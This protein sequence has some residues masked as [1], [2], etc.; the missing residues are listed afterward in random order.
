SKNVW[1]RGVLPTSSRSLC[2]PPARTH[3]CEVVARLYGRLSTPVNTSL[4]WTMPAFVNSSVGS[5]AGTS[6][7]DATI[8]W[9][10]LRKNSRNA[11]R[12]SAAFIA[13][14]LADLGLLPRRLALALLP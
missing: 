2:L 14:K 6:E 12:T 4:N 9:P 13:D 3:F 7:L 10:L 8:S 1:W 11:L 5:L